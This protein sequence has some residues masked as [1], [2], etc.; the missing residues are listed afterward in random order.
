MGTVRELLDASTA[1]LAAGGVER[2]RADAELLLAHA[3]G[4]GLL[5]GDLRLAAA[6]EERIRAH[7]ARR[8]AREPLT[9]I[10]GRTH[11]RGLELA[12]DSRVH[13]PRDDRSGLLVDVAHELPAGTRVH[14]VGTGCGAVALAIK[15]E[16]PDHDV[17]ATDISSA[18][19]EVARANAARLGLVVAF[20]V[21]DN[22]PDGEFD[23]VVANL[24][25]SALCEL[26]SGLP[27]ESARYQPHVALIAGADALDAIRAFVAAAPAG[28]RVAL[29][30]APEQTGEVEA[31]LR[32]A[33]TRRD[34]AGD[35]RM[36]LG[37]VP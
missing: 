18:A 24:P 13:V 30:H 2:P 23:L 5:D 15:H 8:A 33:E 29:E 28:L 6:D 26:Q 14:E 11:F 20:D 27:P 37:L 32:R 21:H 3:L 7:V 12:V 19:I 31:L 9:Y 22:L 36:T 17:S 25:Y 34:A 4:V 16:R 10:L 1:Q 35:E